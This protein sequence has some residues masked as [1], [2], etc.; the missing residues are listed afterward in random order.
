MKAIIAILAVALVLALA[1]VIEDRSASTAEIDQS[2]KEL[3]VTLKQAQDEDARYSGGLVKALIDARIETVKNSI[4]MLE[5]KRQSL[6]HRVCLGYEVRG[7][8]VTPASPEELQRIE[9]D[10]HQTEQELER[11]RA[12][13]AKYSGGLVKGLIEARIAT[14]Q[15]TLAELN[16]RYLFAKYG[17]PPLVPLQSQGTSAPARPAVPDKG[18]L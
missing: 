13:D 2:L 3:N 11:A 9:Q 7:A 5:Q 15:M 4:A 12:E 8:A 16:Q 1:Y 17:L 6:L 18:A 10:V 14:D